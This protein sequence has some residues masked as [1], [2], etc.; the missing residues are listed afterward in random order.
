MV[1]PTH[2]VVLVEDDGG[3]RQAVTRMLTGAGYCVRAFDSAEALLDALEGAALWDG[4]SCLVCDVRLPGAS[5]LELHRRIATRGAM[6]PWIFITAHDD[7]I[8]REQTERA[9]ATF[10]LKPFQGRALLA[11]VERAT[12]APPAVKP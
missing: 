10:L 9:A 8:V 3:M 12:S 4:S 1:H 2:A 11:L 5:G 7:Q 6:P